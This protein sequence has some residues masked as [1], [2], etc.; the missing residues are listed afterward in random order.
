MELFVIA[1][2]VLV[3]FCCMH[4]DK[5]FF[6]LCHIFSEILFLIAIHLHHSYVRIPFFLLHIPFILHYKPKCM[7]LRDEAVVQTPFVA[8]FVEVV[9]VKERL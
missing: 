5:P 8:W 7:Y 3:I 2:F 1:F 9:G 6:Q 4:E